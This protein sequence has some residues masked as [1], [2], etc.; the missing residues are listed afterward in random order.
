MLKKKNTI[1]TG[2]F[3]AI[4]F[5]V[6]NTMI[7]TSTSL[8]TKTEQTNKTLGANIIENSFCF[9]SG[10]TTNTGFSGSSDSPICIMESITI[11]KKLDSAQGS[12]FTFGLKGIHTAKDTLHGIINPGGEDPEIGIIGFTGIK[13]KISNEGDDGLYTYSYIGFALKVAIVDY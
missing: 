3:L 7:T 4:V 6:L 9:V 2:L 13:Q 8:E 11:G 12:V 10:R 1:K 5:I